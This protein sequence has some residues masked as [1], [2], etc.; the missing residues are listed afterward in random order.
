MSANTDMACIGHFPALTPCIA[1][2]NHDIAI[3]VPV[4]AQ[5]AGFV[6]Y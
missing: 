6:D 3:L 4:D 2:G 5:V 1:F